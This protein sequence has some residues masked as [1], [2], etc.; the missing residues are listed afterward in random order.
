MGDS[1]NSLEE[2]MQNLQETQENLF[3]AY[4]MLEAAFSNM[5]TVRSQVANQS[6]S[7]ASSTNSD[8]GP[9]HDAILLSGMDPSNLPLT[10]R[11]VGNEPFNTRAEA[12]AGSPPS[13][14]AVLSL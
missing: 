4:A 1:N 6:A 10:F 11:A 14:H 13:S 7:L 5:T 9:A 12:T 3:R 2:S 8:M